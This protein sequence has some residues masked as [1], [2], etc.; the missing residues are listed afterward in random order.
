LKRIISTG[1]QGVQRAA[2]DVARSRH[3]LWGGACMRGRMDA[4]GRIPD[5]YFTTDGESGLHEAPSTRPS[6]PAFSNARTADGTLILTSG[7]VPD[8]CKR[9]ITDLRNSEGQYLIVDP[10]WN[11]RS[12]PE[13]VQWIVEH[14]L[15]IVNVTGAGS[16]PDDPLVQRSI[17]LL[18]DIISYTHLHITRGVKIWTL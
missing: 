17:L 7:A 2:L 13:A 15:E 10:F 5:S 9:V 4:Y 14:D 1:L 6:L 11:R 8:L 18:N 16:T 3:T 12:V